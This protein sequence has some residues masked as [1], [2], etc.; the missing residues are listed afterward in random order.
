MDL[1]R[2]HGSHGQL[3]LAS[4][5]QLIGLNVLVSITAREAH[6]LSE[7]D[8]ALLREYGASEK[9]LAELRAQAATAPSTQIFDLDFEAQT[10]TVNRDHG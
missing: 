3:A 6:T 8:A 5:F 7:D 2:L 10:V 1:P 9:L 4:L